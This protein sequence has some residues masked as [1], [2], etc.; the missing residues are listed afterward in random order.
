MSLSLSIL[1][2]L[3]FLEGFWGFFDSTRLELGEKQKKQRYKKD[4][5]HNFHLPPPPP[6]G[7]FPP[8][9]SVILRQPPIQNRD[10]IEHHPPSLYTLYMPVGDVR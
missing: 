7:P 6:F 9:P 8:F 5:S 4:I 3:F 1:D 10:N 2:H